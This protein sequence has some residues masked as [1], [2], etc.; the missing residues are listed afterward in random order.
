[1]IL[2]VY[3]MRDVHTGFLTPTFEVNDQVARRNF[4]HAVTNAG[5]DS[6]LSSHSA[7]FALYRLGTF[8]SDSGH[9]ESILPEF[10]LSGVDAWRPAAK[11]EES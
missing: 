1:M 11:K 2:S 9:F 3:A 10:L 7:D 8:D 6:V 5:V 4:V